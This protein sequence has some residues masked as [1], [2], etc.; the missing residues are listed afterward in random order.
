MRYKISYEKRALRELNKLP[1][2]AIDQI[3]KRID[4]LEENPYQA[5]VRK[6]SLTHDLYRIRAGNYRIIYEICDGELRIIIISIGD[7]KNV[8]N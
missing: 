7:R 3:I 4:S 5:G 8:Y 2:M 6:L 1:R